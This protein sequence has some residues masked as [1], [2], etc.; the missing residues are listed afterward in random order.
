[1]GNFTDKEYQI[2][3]SLVLELKN[4]EYKF[5]VKYLGGPRAFPAKKSTDT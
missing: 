4:P 2:L 3:M 1:L 5:D